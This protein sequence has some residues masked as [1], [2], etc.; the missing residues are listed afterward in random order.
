MIICHWITIIYHFYI[1]RNIL[2]I[3]NNPLTVGHAD[4]FITIYKY[5]TL[6]INYLTGL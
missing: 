3:A 2:K 6:D 4:I 1:S 5:T